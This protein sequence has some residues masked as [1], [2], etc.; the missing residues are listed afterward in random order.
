MIRIRCLLSSNY[1]TGKDKYFETKDA[2]FGA[3]KLFYFQILNLKI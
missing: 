2:N 3:N 1:A